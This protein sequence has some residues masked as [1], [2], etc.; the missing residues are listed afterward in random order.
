[1]SKNCIGGY[2]RQYIFVCSFGLF[3]LEGAHN[4]GGYGNVPNETSP[5]PITAYACDNE[6]V[7]FRF[8]AEI[9]RIELVDIALELKLE[10]LNI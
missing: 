2:S 6:S 4:V 10:V 5:L 3:D 8:C 9:L 7:L 1:L